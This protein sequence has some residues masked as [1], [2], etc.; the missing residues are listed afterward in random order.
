M[1]PRAALTLLLALGGPLAAQDATGRWSLQVRG[2]AEVDRGDLRIEAA[3]G[4]LLLE[5]Q[6]TLWQVLEGFHQ[7]EG[8]VA[9]STPG[10]RR[11]TGTLRGDEMTGTVADPGGIS[12]P[13]RAGR[14]QPG[15]V[16]WPVRPRVM[17]RQLLVGTAAAASAY[18]T[19][20]REAL[21]PTAVLLA[22]H[23][24]LASGAGMPTVGL[25]QI[26]RRA[27][28]I[29]LGL[30]S[31]GLA[32]SA[33]VLEAIAAG[34][35]AD[36]DFR[37]LFVANDGGWRL[38]LH[39]VAWHAARDQVAAD[40]LVEQDLGRLLEILGL[41]V[42]DPD[43]MALRRAVWTYWQRS[44]GDRADLEG[45]AAAP[46]A[47]IAR[48]AN[49]LRALMA[50]YILA[51]AWWL[52]AV[53]WLMTHRWVAVPEG[54]RSPVELV[55]ALWERPDLTL[56]PIEIR[57]FGVAQAV[58]VIGATS[59]G[60]R[61]LLGA[62][63]VADEYLAAPGGFEESLDAWRA[64]EF[65]ESTPLQ[66]EFRGQPL[67][68]VSPASV[69]RSRLG[70][71]LAAHDAIR[72]E[73]G[74]AP[75]VAV[76]TVIHEWQH[77]LLEGS[78]LIGVPSPGLLEEHWGLRLLEG[79]PWLAEGA[80]EWLTEVVLAPGGVS[81]VALRLLEAEKRL[82]IAARTPDDTHT[83]GY[84]LVRAA[85]ARIDDPHLMRRLLV[86]SL[87]DPRA[88]AAVAGFGGGVGPPLA[89]PPTLL[90][91]PEVSFTMDGGVADGASRRLILPDSPSE[92]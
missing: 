61:L 62:N 89:R 56:P 16:R 77:L 9:F 84:L 58:P 91:I 33:S 30:D 34:P 50:G 8:Q 53:E 12:F 10:G 67:P 85:A 68:L 5:S 81:V 46:D 25:D 51:E 86:A 48:A 18:P 26:A 69:A 35:A 54:H 59:L 17:V 88:I 82:A 29:A 15:T 78:R 24:A 83:L 42:A 36:A 7:R 74:I 11:F 43:P 76:G 40:A 47:A 79:D 73:S 66:L 49:G 71:F 41:P 21:P 32:L 19:G 72:I 20:W 57:H 22:E 80:A 55:A 38:D 13:W 23:A 44:A 31:T 6:D 70:G 1:I 37:A 39:T 45:L 2:P 4:R 64:L 65:I 3:G 75:V 52:E 92:P 28:G 27:G 14:I 87:H 63:G 90:M 60:A